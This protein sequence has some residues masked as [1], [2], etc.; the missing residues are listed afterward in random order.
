M[1]FCIYCEDESMDDDFCDMCGRKLS[2]S[3]DEVLEDFNDYVETTIECIVKRSTMNKNQRFISESGL[4][5]V[6]V[7][8]IPYKDNYNLLYF[9]KDESISLKDYMQ[10]EYLD[11]E[12]LVTIIVRVYRMIKEINGQGFVL[13]SLDIS[14]LWLKG[15]NLSTLYL[16]QSRRFLK[17]ITD[18][19]DY[20]F[21]E[22]SG[23]GVVGLNKEELDQGSDISLL[24][25]LYMSLA[26]DMKFRVDDYFHERYIG[27]NLGMFSDIAEKDLHPWINRTVNANADIRYK[28][29]E[30]CMDDFEYLLQSRYLE[31][32]D[33]G[34]ELDLC[35]S[36]H[37]GIGKNL[38]M[39]DYPEE[40][41]NEDSI[42]VSEKLC[43]EG[44]K[45]SNKALLLVAD[46]I[47]TSTIGTGYEASNIIKSVAEN[48]WDEEYTNIKD[49][50]DVQGFVNEI[51]NKSNQEIRNYVYEREG[52]YCT[53]RVVMGSTLS[54]AIRIDRNLYY[55]S[56]GDSPML[57]VRKDYVVPLNYQDNRGNEELVNGCSWER[58]TEMDGSS[59]LTNFVGGSN[60]NKEKE[61]IIY[62]KV[63][64]IS[65]MKDEYILLCSDGLTD[66]IE[67]G[68]GLDIGWS[69]DEKL[70]E[71]IYQDGDLSIVDIVDNLISTANYYGGGD[72]ISVILAKTK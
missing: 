23:I 41:R 64:E 25:R 71:L 22:V 33:D 58:F 45:S 40:V 44:D 1:A 69:T 30:E 43:Y 70:K 48:L 5:S 55:A 37:V 65:L 67:P 51:I 66:Y 32:Q 12:D 10:K 18:L 57:L 7:E 13:G 29:L 4:I 31:S 28:T 59:S 19:V 26:T 63:S 14:D 54:I 24:G 38:K 68:T 52:Y 2:E 9:V 47:S 6:P 60:Y 34:I 8:V 21:G 27:Y 16:R 56:V 72:N 39:K 11:H 3:N 53:N 17:N 35:A 15:D 50:K 49:S 62:P 46:G 42:L 36:T 61:E 20:E